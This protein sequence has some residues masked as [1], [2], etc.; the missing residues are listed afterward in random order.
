MTIGGT[1]LNAVT[2]L[3]F[4]SGIAIN[5]FHATSDTQIVASI[6][7][8]SHAAPGFRSVSVTTASG[9]TVSLGSAFRVIEYVAPTYSA[10]G[11]YEQFTG[12]LGATSTA[13]IY[14]NNQV[15]QTFTPTKSHYFNSASLWMYRTGTPNFI[16]TISL[17][18]TSAGQP[19]GSPLCTTTCYAG[20]LPTS[21]TTWRTLPFA[22]GYQVSAGTTYALVI[23]ATGGTRSNLSNRINIRTYA[24]NGYTRGQLGAS[25]DAGAS[26][27]MNPSA[28]MAFKEGQDPW[29]ESQTATTPGIT[30]SGLNQAFQTFTPARTHYLNYVSLYLY[31]VGSP[32]YTVTISLHNVDGSGQPTGSALCSTTFLASSLTT[33]AAWRSYRFP[34]GYQVSAGT[35]YALVFSASGSYG[36]VVLQTNT[37]D[38]YNNGDCGRSTDGGTTWLTISG[39]DLAFREGDYPWYSAFASSNSAAYVYGNNQLCQTFTPAQSHYFEYAGLYLYKL[40]LPDYTITISLYNTDE[41]HQPTGSAL[42][43]T[44]FAASS[45]TLPKPSYSTFALYEF[46]FTS[47]CNLSQGTEYALVLSANGGDPA[48]CVATRIYTK[49]YYYAGQRGSS[50]DGG[51]TWTM[52]PTQDMTFYEGGMN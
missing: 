41:N 10:S 33:K 29:H 49:N 48:N 32:T 14:G 8:D 50:T 2:S 27:T 31:K 38:G 9:E 1:A 35:T 43:S 5:G 45:I 3:S 39:P 34:S 19:S 12:Q 17:Y 21:L 42:C 36:Y 51:T 44:T 30:V 13:Y 18:N 11:T 7:I 4:G 20:S 6:T 52:L 15:C 37:V 25:T 40:G 24:A 46:R 23:S 16:I 22:T 28:D 47:G 26:W